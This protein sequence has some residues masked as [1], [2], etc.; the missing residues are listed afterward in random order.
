MCNENTTSP[1][2]RPYSNSSSNSEQVKIAT[3][4][5]FSIDDTNTN[6]NINCENGNDINNNS[7]DS[8]DLIEKIVQNNSEID[9]AE[10]FRLQPYDQDQRP[11]LKTQNFS[12]TIFTYVVF[13]FIF[14][15]S[16]FQGVVTIQF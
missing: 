14:L 16:T 2:K 10:L 8:N 11:V 15:K 13:Y 1:N 9:E 3:Q 5:C 6:L 4:E 12:K 7:S